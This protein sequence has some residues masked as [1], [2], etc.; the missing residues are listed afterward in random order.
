MS[1]GREV[2]IGRLLGLDDHGLL[3]K[4][5]TDL[6]PRVEIIDLVRRARATGVRAAVL[7]NS[8]G[9]GDHDPYD[10][11]DLEANFDAIVISDRVGLRKPSPEIYRLTAHKIGLPPAECV[12]VD[13]TEHNLSA[14]RDLGMATLLFT[15][16]DGEAAEIKRLIGIA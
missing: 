4:A 8:R 12:F 15:G 1:L 14:A 3:A 11:Y 2:T 7:S 10:G 5:G 9:T 6:R 13:D 16:A